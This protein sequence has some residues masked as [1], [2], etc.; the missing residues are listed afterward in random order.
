[1]QV[2]T[3]PAHHPEIALKGSQIPHHRS[4]QMRRLP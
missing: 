1:M 4:A 3:D 2:R